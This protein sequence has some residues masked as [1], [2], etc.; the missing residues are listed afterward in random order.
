MRILW[1]ANTPCGASSKFGLPVNSGGWLNALEQQISK[2]DNIELHIAFHWR[3]DSPSIKIDRTTYHPI[4]EIR[5]RSAILQALFG[6]R[7]STKQKNKYLELINDVQ[8]D[9]IHI[10]GT[11][12][13][14]SL[15]L[16]NTQI[17]CIVSIQ[18][19][20]S[21][22]SEKYF[23]G[24]SPLNFFMHEP[25]LDHIKLKS[26]L[27]RYKIFLANAKRERECLKKASNVIGRTQWDKNSSTVLAPFAKYWHCDELLGEDFLKAKWTKEAYSNPFRIITITGNA[28]YKGFETI[29]KTCEILDA[30]NFEY[31]WEVIGLAQNSTIIKASKN[32]ARIS[33]RISFKGKQNSTYIS[34]ALS[35]A[36]CYIQVSHIENS[37]NSLCEAMLVGV[38]VIASFAG[39]T[40]SLFTP[41]SMS[42]LFQDGD[43]WSL[44]GTIIQKSRSFD[45]SKFIANELKQI[46]LNRHD[47]S[48]ITDR[49]TEIYTNLISA[50]IKSPDYSD[51][52]D[53]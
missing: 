39:G 31:Q 2:I 20:L 38:P 23:S 28:P 47:G 16:G 51:Q 24:I 35:E 19:I 25:F 18:G 42:C 3:E 21:N 49:M 9:I 43:S 6:I 30:L 7:V 4:K 48:S 34:K 11:E 27:S 40:S 15:I 5:T 29:A 37:P 46:A 12:Q 32:L 41:T 14:F 33:P 10:H 1:F 17:P 8:P 45:Q 50:K 36:D 26:A 53:N 44:A 13:S 52:N 22:Y